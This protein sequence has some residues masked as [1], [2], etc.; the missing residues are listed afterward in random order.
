[1]AVTQ[2]AL[3]REMNASLKCHSSWVTRTGQCRG[4]CRGLVQGGVTGES[5]ELTSCAPCHGLWLL[6]CF[7]YHNSALSTWQLRCLLFLTLTKIVFSGVFPPC[8]IL[9]YGC[10]AVTQHKFLGLKSKFYW[11]EILVF[12]GNTN[13]NHSKVLLYP[14]SGKTSSHSLC[15]SGSCN[16]RK[17]SVFS[18]QTY[19]F[20]DFHYTIPRG[21]PAVNTLSS[22]VSSV[23]AS[24][25]LAVFSWM[26]FLEKTLLDSKALFQ[27]SQNWLINSWQVIMHPCMTKS[28]QMMLLI[29]KYLYW[30]KES[31]AIPQCRV[32]PTPL[33][34]PI[35]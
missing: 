34:L 17:L 7:R 26:Y 19:L 32:V 25:C 20:S 18:F 6:P 33:S 13:E 31:T 15:Q 1:M 16:D 2:A 8:H 23:S 28:H 24:S 29:N 12:T 35:L 21:C 9:K 14:W 5:S 4:D 30:W 3:L 22:A 11:C 10:A 27:W